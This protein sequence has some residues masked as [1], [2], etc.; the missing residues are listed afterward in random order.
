MLGVVGRLGCDALVHPE[1]KGFAESDF[2]IT[3]FLYMSC[4]DTHRR[5]AIFGAIRTQ[6]DR[7]NYGK[8][9]PN[10]RRNFP[11][12]FLPSLHREFFGFAPLQRATGGLRLVSISHATTLQTQ[13]F[14]KK[15]LDT[16][17][18]SN[19]MSDPVFS[20]IAI[21]RVGSASSGSPAGPLREP[22]GSSF[23]A[24]GPRFRRK[25]AVS[26]P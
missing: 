16:F 20:K 4:L 8:N 11:R 2:I 23:P 1:G 15:P 14:L 12:N 21:G 7:F 25:V 9:L 17:T 5:R 6:R 26:L 18:T 24:T 10:P 13:D 22:R 3:I 19:I